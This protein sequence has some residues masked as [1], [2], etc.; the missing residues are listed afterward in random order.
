MEARSKIMLVVLGA[1]VAAYTAWTLCLMIFALIAE[2]GGK[3]SKPLLAAAL[4]WPLGEAIW[5]WVWFAR[6]Q[7]EYLA[8]P[9][10]VVGHALLI[11]AL[12]AP[13]VLTLSL[14]GAVHWEWGIIIPI[15]ITIIG[16]WATRALWSQT[17]D[18][19]AV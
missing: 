18:E 2:S 1:G 9:R 7:K 19:V 15:P 12:L 13:P 14:T 3:D 8:S 5:T 6:H 16:C 17:A 11:L 4:L 10:Q